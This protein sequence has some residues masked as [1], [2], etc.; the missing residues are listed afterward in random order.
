MEGSQSLE[1]RT[2]LTLHDLNLQNHDFRGTTDTWLRSVDFT[3]LKA[4]QVWDCAGIDDLLDGLLGI[5]QTQHL[6]LNGLVLSIEYWDYS[7]KLVIQFLS[8]ISSLEYLNLSLPNPQPNP[9]AFSWEVLE[10]HKHSIR[11]LYLGIGSNS[12]SGTPLQVLSLHDFD[13]LRL[14]FL[15]LRQLAIALPALRMDDA[16]AGRWKDYRWALERLASL[17]KLKVLR[18]LTWPTASGRPFVAEEDNKGA[19]VAQSKKY[20]KQLDIIAASIAHL[21]SCLRT[22]YQQRLSVIVFGSAQD[23]DVVSHISGEA[24]RLVAGP[25]TY[26]VR[27]KETEFGLLTKAKRIDPR[28]MKYEEPIA[29]VVDEG[30]DQ[31]LSLEA[32]PWGRQS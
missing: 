3:K 25:I 12:S 8:C 16:L 4:L 23:D 28:E 30:T 31:G 1:S 13:W 24:C 17:P 22:S 20:L 14:N 18:I 21:F 26:K 15:N 27:R 19:W 32:Y 11:D 29:F 2:K 6:Q 5:A 7:L 10:Q 9:Q